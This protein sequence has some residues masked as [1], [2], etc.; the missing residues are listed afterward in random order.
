[1]N[2]QFARV[3]LYST[4]LLSMSYVNYLLNPLISPPDTCKT[5]TLLLVIIMSTWNAETFS[6]MCVCVCLKTDSNK[7]ETSSHYSEERRRV[8]DLKISFTDQVNEDKEGSE[9]ERETERR[10]MYAYV[11]DRSNSLSTVC[12]YQ[13]IG[14]RERVKVGIGKWWWAFWRCFTLWYNVTRKERK[15]K[16]EEKWRPCV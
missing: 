9:K 6:S 11:F 1:M 8:R 7:R 5:N 2:A 14:R 15:T 13:V 16:E 4:V 3:S 10:Y 12:L